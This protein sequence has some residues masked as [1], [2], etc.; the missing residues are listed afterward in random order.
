MHTNYPQRA[1]SPAPWRLPHAPWRGGRGR[2]ARISTSPSNRA[3]ARRSAA[4]LGLRVQLGRPM[5]RT[6]DLRIV[7]K[8]T[9]RGLALFTIVRNEDYFLP[10]FFDHYRSIG[11]ETFL[12]YDDRS[13]APTKAFLNAQAD[14]TI[15]VSEHS[16]GDDFGVAVTGAPRRL[17]VVLKESVPPWAFPDRWVLTVDA[18]EFLILP[19]GLTDLPQLVRRLDQIGQPYLTASMVD[20]Y[21][22][23][24]NH[25]NYDRR[26]SPFAANPFFDAGPYYHWNGK[27]GPLRIPAGFRHR[28]LMTLQREHPAEVE[29]IYGDNAYH[30]KTWKVPLL[31]NGAGVDRIEDHEITVPPI[32]TLTGALAHFKFYPDLDL[33]IE[34]ALSEG[35]YY[36][37]SQE[38]AFLRSATRLLGDAPL[39]GAETRTFDGPHALEQAQLIRRT[40]L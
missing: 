12:V 7:K 35:Q 25:R 17:P 21:G 31:K 29:R 34:T 14:C 2:P 4:T 30:A 33:K 13:D 40:A 37:G 19:T 16:F 5:S 32:D 18:D 23:T 3:I 28:L 26:L 27:L 6:L 20:F 36:N 24:L 1:F 39:V 10:F 38:Y 11:I 8:A 15:L 9:T 22:P